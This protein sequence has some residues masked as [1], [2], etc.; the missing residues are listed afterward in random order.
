L[1]SVCYSDIFVTFLGVNF[2]HFKWLTFKE[3]G[4]NFTHFKWLTFKE[5]IF[6]QLIIIQHKLTH[7]SNLRLKA[8][9]LELIIII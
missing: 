5:L 1:T 6:E 7:L 2:T 3:L 8:E 4:V 9:P